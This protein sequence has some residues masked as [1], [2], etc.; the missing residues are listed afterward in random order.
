MCGFEVCGHQDSTNSTDQGM[1][2]QSAHLHIS[3]IADQ[4]GFVDTFAVDADDST[5]VSECP[6]LPAAEP[7]LCNDGNFVGD[8]NSDSDTD[9]ETDASTTSTTVGSN[10][11]AGGVSQPAI[12]L[13]T[14]VTAAAAAFLA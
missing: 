2:F 4:C 5:A 11:A 14:A 10:G 6:T 12:V 1:D 13:A 7:P 3:T 9:R 8:Q